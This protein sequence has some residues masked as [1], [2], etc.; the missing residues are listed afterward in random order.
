MQL[1][2]VSVPFAPEQASTFAPEV[3][4]LYLYLIL[5]TLFFSVLITSLI[6]YFAIK[7]RRRDPDELPR[8]RAGSLVLE[9]L[10]SV[11]PLL[12][13]MTI[14]AWGA[15]TYFKLYRPPQEAMQVYVVG[16]Q[17]MWKFQHQTGQREINELHVPVGARV[18]LTMTTE[19]VIHSLFIPA[20][21]LKMDVVPGKYTNAWF[22]ATKT[23]TFYLFC[24]EYCG[25]NHSGMGGHI[26]VMEPTA[27]QQWL[28]G[29]TSESAAGQGGK[30]F[31]ERGCNRSGIPTPVHHADLSG[32][33]ERG[34]NPATDRLSPLARR[35]RAGRRDGV[36]DGQQ[37]RDDHDERRRA[38]HTTLEPAR[39]DATR[40]RTGRRRRA[41]LDFAG[42]DALATHGHAS[43]APVVARAFARAAVIR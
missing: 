1:P 18:R 40:A 6:I 13:S 29:G 9:S 25:T 11:I 7:Y 10:W 12:I 41:G 8:P 35:A 38:R 21:R 27:Y 30:I 15:S 3:D 37:R 26:V 20:F 22:E 19:D 36:G 5:I 24:A 33:V 34:A 42:R 23:G 16:K 28:S 4:A 39:A 14:F 17:W 31:Q 32:A 2:Q 43:P